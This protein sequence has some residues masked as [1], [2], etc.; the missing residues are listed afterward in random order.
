MKT[1]LR[2]QF[3]GLLEKKI[4]HGKSANTT[5]PNF[6][7]SIKLFVLSVRSFFFLF[8]V[9]IFFPLLASFSSK[10]TVLKYYIQ[11]YISSHMETTLNEGKISFAVQLYFISSGQFLQHKVGSLISMVSPALCSRFWGCHAMQRCL[12]MERAQAA[13]NLSA[14]A[15]QRR[16]LFQSTPKKNTT[17][18]S[19]LYRLLLQHSL[20]FFFKFAGQVT[21]LMHVHQQGN[22]PRQHA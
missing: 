5:G 8:S 11:V 12:E 14:E 7:S 18:L 22:L 17:I 10:S 13:C 6:F 4:Y 1:S 20:V 15:I 9:F 21:N 19:T 16:M 2:K 3:H